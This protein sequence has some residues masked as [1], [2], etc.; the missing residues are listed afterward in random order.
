MRIE[1]AI[2]QYRLQLYLLIF[3]SFRSKP[4]DQGRVVMFKD[5]LAA[6]LAL[7][8]H[9]PPIMTVVIMTGYVVHGY[10]VGDVLQGTSPGENQSK[11][12]GL[13]IMAKLHELLIVGSLTSL[14]FTLIRLELCRG[15]GIPFSALTAKFHIAD[16][17][18][19]WSKEFVSICR[20]DFSCPTTK[21]LLVALIAVCTALTVALAPASAT[22]LIPQNRQWE[23]GGTEIWLNATEDRL[24]PLEINASHIVGKNCNIAGDPLCPSAHWS[25][26]KDGFAG[27]L[28]WKGQQ[29]FRH[30]HNLNVP[31][32]GTEIVIK[33]HV[34]SPPVT[35]DSVAVV[36]QIAL[37]RA[38]S[39]NAI[40][41][42][43]ATQK[44]WVAG[45]SRFKLR[46]SERFEI[47]AKSYKSYAICEGMNYTTR[48][49]ADEG[50]IVPVFPAPDRRGH[51]R[52]F[53]TESREL[54]AWKKHLPTISQPEILWLDSDVWNT[55]ASLRAAVAIPDSA[56]PSRFHL[57][58][59]FMDVRRSE[60]T[61][62]QAMSYFQVHAQDLNFRIPVKNP[63]DMESWKRGPKAPS[64]P[65]QV[66]VRP[67]Y[68]QYLN[69]R[70]NKETNRTVFSELALSSH[71]WTPD[72]PE[73]GSGLSH[74]LE[75][76]LNAM[77]MNGLARVEP[78]TVAL[79]T[80]RDIDDPGWWEDFLPSPQ[81]VFAFGSK[82]GSAYQ[83]TDAEKKGSSL[84]R[85]K[86]F[87]GGYGYALLDSSLIGAL[88]ILW[89]Y[90]VIISVYITWSVV[91]GTST[92]SW[93]SMSEM[94]ALALKSP[95][96]SG[97][98]FDG[99]SAGI[100]SIVPLRQRYYLRADDD[101]LVLRSK[102]DRQPTDEDVKV[103][104]IYR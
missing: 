32:N 61:Y 10:F 56:S 27:T 64:S 43:Q 39:E 72:G 81:E 50:R 69:P 58:G 104:V 85:L 79:G 42:D 31:A 65:K 87:A 40:L 20:G 30:D 86:V 52:F 93:D 38:L 55:S 70:L 33:L 82:S 22:V 60:T 67:A 78:H 9:F 47:A 101:R 91:T 97:Q 45:Y 23:A 44:A 28:P 11:L 89:L 84:Y 24:W 5:R 37:A 100:S 73:I 12:V 17:S 19:L 1:N 103:N 80:R 102:D 74:H 75:A 18:F 62:F 46:Q 36:P 57:Y 92:T 98:Q 6:A 4:R 68:L 90:V 13:Q 99:T 48:D 25:F 2:R 29:R 3:Q 76:I 7:W 88:S 63:E 53:L 54:P 95:A 83:V 51:H 71:L 49:D 77:L 94:L 96:P 59:C 66:Q 34:A 41:W 35:F 14:V 15:R 26:L 8:Y 16:I 21:R